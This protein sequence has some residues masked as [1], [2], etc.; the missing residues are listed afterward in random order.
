MKNYE[1]RIE[2]NIGGV[3]FNE[4]V[5]ASDT[6]K[7]LSKAIIVN[8]LDIKYN[9]KVIVKRVKKLEIIRGMFVEGEKVYVRVDNNIVV[10]RVYYSVEAG[11]LYI[12]YNSNKY[13]YYDFI[14]EED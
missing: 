11:D 12:I 14:K 7:A 3:V 8:N 1:I 4:V 9:D 6:I 5:S 13:F 10:R 2:N